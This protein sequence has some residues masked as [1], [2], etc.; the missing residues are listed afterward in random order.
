[1]TLVPPWNSD[2]VDHVISALKT[3]KYPPF[4]IKLDKIT[5]GPT[6]PYQNLAG[7]RRMIWAT[8]VTP[9]EMLDLRLKIYDV[10]KQTL[11][12][13]PFRLHMTLARLRPEDFENFTVK[14]LNLLIN[15]TQKVDRFVL[16]ESRLSPGGS[17]YKILEEFKI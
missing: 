16:Y 1:V 14:N 11:D 17:D 12:S 10:L 4:E 5:F 7:R 2:G 15:F 8:G 6:P 9:K 13:R 3:V